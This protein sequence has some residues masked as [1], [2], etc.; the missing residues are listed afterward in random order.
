MSDSSDANV[1]VYV[2]DIA[3][4]GSVR[5]EANQ[6]RTDGAGDL[7]F[8]RDGVE[9]A[10]YVRDQYRSYRDVTDEGPPFDPPFVVS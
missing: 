1:R 3:S 8:S 7:V 4:K 6:V 5:I 2:V 10:R 9:C